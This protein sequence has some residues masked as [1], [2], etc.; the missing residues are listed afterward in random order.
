MSDYITKVVPYEPFEVDLIE[1]W[2]DEL[3]RKGLILREIRLVFARFQ[4]ASPS[5][6]RFRLDKPPKPDPVHDRK[7]LLAENGWQ[8]VPTFLCGYAVYKTEDP[9]LLELPTEG[10]TPN[11]STIWRELSIPLSSFLISIF[12]L[13]SLYDFLIG[14]TYLLY[15]LIS[16]DRFTLV[17]IHL[18]L[19]LTFFLL[20]AMQIRALYKRK[21]R[22][23]SG[24]LRLVDQHTKA[25]QRFQIISKSVLPVITVVLLFGIHFGFQIQTHGICLL[26]YKHAIPF[27]LLDEINPEEG[28]A[29]ISVLSSDDLVLS[30]SVE[31]YIWKEHGVFVP[32]LVSLRQSGPT[33][34][35]NDSTYR[36]LY[37]Y[38]VNYYKILSRPLAERFAKE[39][40][41]MFD[42]HQTVSTNK[43]VHAWY[44]GTVEGQTLLIQY[45]AVILEVWYR[46]SSDLRDCIP[47]FEAHLGAQ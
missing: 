37:T 45:E 36:S 7:A 41:L 46:G 38:S 34:Q 27:P 5:T 13:S 40:S 35:V 47:L 10:A 25:W 43:D 23:K 11:P 3:A 39:L 21:Q 26:D 9:F 14:Q 32:E 8:H 20:A 4:K 1:T 16:G 6:T 28:E 29:L 30:S 22:I 19:G 18:L 33:V 2:L 31:N 42:A 24:R 44:S 12:F 17:S 15:A